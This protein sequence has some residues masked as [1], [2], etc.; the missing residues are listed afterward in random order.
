MSVNSALPGGVVRL[1]EREGRVHATLSAEGP[2]GAA[3]HEMVD[4]ELTRPQG[5]AAPH[6]DVAAVAAAKK[7]EWPLPA[8]FVGGDSLRALRLGS[9]VQDGVEG[10]PAG[11]GG[12]SYIRGGPAGAGRDSGSLSLLRTRAFS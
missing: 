8:L 4:G 3:G 7:L 12:G 10:D 9:A 5:S 11:C 1:G 6:A 2:A